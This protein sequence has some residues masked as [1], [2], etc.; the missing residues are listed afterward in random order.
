[1]KL[2]LENWREYLNEGTDTT[3][4]ILDALEKFKDYNR[5]EQLFALLDALLGIENPLYKDL[6][7]VFD[8]LSN[9]HRVKEGYMLLKYMKSRNSNKNVIQK[10]SIRDILYDYSD[11]VEEKYNKSIGTPE[12]EYWREKKKAVFNTIEEM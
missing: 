11:E 12:E 2:L 9:E 3:A 7:D 5:D 10:L 4:Q 1:M 8:V 6:K